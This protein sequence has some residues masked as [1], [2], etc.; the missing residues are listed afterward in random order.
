MTLGSTM[1]TFAPYSRMR[2]SRML[3]TRPRRRRLE[4]RHRSES[5]LGKRFG[6]T[7]ALR[8]CSIRIPSGRVVALVGP[9]GAGKTTFLRLSAGL[10]EPTAGRIEVLGWSPQG[11]SALVCPR[12]GFL[13]LRN[14]PFMGASR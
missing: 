8:D 7:W 10:D 11:H 3:T 14:G 13:L 5:G 4:R 12:I 6:S 2:F 1:A 9:N